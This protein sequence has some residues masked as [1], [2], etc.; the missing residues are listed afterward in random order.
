MGAFVSYFFSGFILGKIP[1]PLSPSF[2]LML[3]VLRRPPCL[4]QRW[5]CA[6][7]RRHTVGRPRQQDG[8]GCPN[9]VCW[10][11]VGTRQGMT[12]E[13]QPRP[14]ST[15][16]WGACTGVSRRT[17]LLRKVHANH[18]PW[19]MRCVGYR[20]PKTS[21]ARGHRHTCAHVPLGPWQ[22]CDCCIC[23]R[24]TKMLHAKPL[25]LRGGAVAAPGQRPLVNL[26]RAR[27]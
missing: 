17:C 1:F 16:S 19:V 26:Q 11:V 12:R 18:G 24:T 4:A 22:A 6:G 13:R 15:H 8:P 20:G 10:K 25:H 7:E 2:R 27:A 5:V 21:E 23:I 14:C 9:R 3:Q